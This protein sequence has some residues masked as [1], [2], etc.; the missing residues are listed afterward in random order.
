MVIRQMPHHD[1]TAA[2]QN[3][4]EIPTNRLAISRR[5]LGGTWT[6]PRSTR[7]HET[8]DGILFSYNDYVSGCFIR[9]HLKP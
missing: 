8:S 9:A 6:I 3:N 7:G 2:V 4:D 1:Y 5:T